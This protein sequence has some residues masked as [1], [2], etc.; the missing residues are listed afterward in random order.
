MSAR[1]AFVRGE[2]LAL[3]LDVDGTLL[4]IAATPDRVRVPASLRNTLELARRREHGAF[5]LLSGRPI[6]EL[7]ELFAPCRFP[8][9]GKHGLEVRLPGGEVVRPDIDAGVLDRA[10]QWL[11]SLQRE[12]RGLLLEDKGIALAMHYRLVPRLEPE[13]QA[14]MDELASELGGEF[15]V[16]R[17][18]CVLELMPRAYSERSAIELLM[19]QPEFAGRTPVFVGDDPCD[20]VAFE[21]VN[22]MGGHTIRVGN[23]EQTAARYRFSNVSTV[24]AWLRDR[25][26]N[27]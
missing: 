10:R 3:F 6:A 27:R 14:V 11:Q 17:G 18:K 12:H 20:E 21:A 16:R 9:S 13:V 23:L 19:R 8:A 15:T 26:L 5:A 25:N 2:G 24:V 4:E 1:A 22:E 7:D